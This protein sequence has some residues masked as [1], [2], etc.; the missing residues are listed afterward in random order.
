MIA[1]LVIA[2]LLFL[3]AIMQVGIKLTYDGENA[4]IRLRAGFFRFAL[5][6]KKDKK[7][8]VMKA[9]KEKK[10]PESDKKKKDPVK[11]AKTK[12][13]VKAVMAHFGD[14]MSLLGKVLRSPTLDVLKLH[15]L[16]GASDPEVCAMNYG[17]FQAMAG[18]ALPVV[19]NIF[20]IRKRDIRIDCDF[21]KDNNEM[22]VHAEITVRVY[23]I[24]AIAVAG[25]KL[26][27]NLYRTQKSIYK[28]V[29]VNESSSS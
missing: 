22:N 26:L 2:A 4:G 20:G 3:L 25:M 16:V 23:E 13:W 6:E 15:I 24:I 12:A 21:M 27:I 14:I 7:P 10:L 17:K 19:E 5:P 29:L 9:K 28:A 11:S 18:A 8:K 1:L